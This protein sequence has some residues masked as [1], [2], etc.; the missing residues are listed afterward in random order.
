MVTGIPMSGQTMATKMPN[1]TINM[2]LAM[3]P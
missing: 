2:M 1:T 3:T